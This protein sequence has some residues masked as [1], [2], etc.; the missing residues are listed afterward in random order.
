L[1]LI[2]E[3][4]EKELSRGYLLESIQDKNGGGVVL[5][6]WVRLCE[7]IERQRKKRVMESASGL[8]GKEKRE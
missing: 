8:E 5:V 6:V 2:F 1:D 3:I 7:E 4:G